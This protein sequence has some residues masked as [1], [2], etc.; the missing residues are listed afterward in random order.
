MIFPF[1]LLYLIALLMIFMAIWRICSS[2]V[3][4]LG[5]LKFSSPGVSSSIP[6]SAALVSMISL[7]FS[8]ISRRYTDSS[9]KYISP[10]SSLLISRTSLISDSRYSDATRIFLWYFLTASGLS[11]HLSE[12][13][14]IP[15]IPFIGVRI[16]W[17]ILVRN[18]LFAWFAISSSI[19]FSR[20]TSWNMQPQ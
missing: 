19:F 5:G 20:E 12:I 7:Q 17:D 8:S 3:R 14:S 4:T 11:R 1:G 13:S 15:M 2:L 9:A 18:S 10:E 16:S 6:C